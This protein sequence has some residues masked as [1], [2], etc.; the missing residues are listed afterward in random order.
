LTTAQGNYK[1]AVVVVE[2]FTKWIEAKPLVN[3]VV[4]LK[5][6]FWQNIIC[7][8]GV[9]RKI[10]FN[11]A[12]QFDCHT[13]KDFCPLIGVEATFASVYHPQSN[14]VVE[15]ANTIIFIA[16]KKIPEDQLKGKWAEELPRAV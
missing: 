2:Y 16:I 5:G 7:H 12:K 14:G 10:T 4:G 9:P 13:F 6:F 8:F 11:N 1:Y 3:I 15:K